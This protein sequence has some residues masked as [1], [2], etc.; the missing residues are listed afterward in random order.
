[1]SPAAIPAP[2]TGPRVEIEIARGIEAIA[3]A[4]WDACAAPG[5]TAGAHAANPFV[6]HAFLAALEASG[7]AT[8]ATGW[9]PHHLVARV[10][11]RVEAVMPLY[12]KGHS[13][14]EYVFDHAWANAWHRAGGAYYPKLQS[15]VPFTPATGP[16]LM[17]RPDAVLGVAPMQAALIG[18]ARDL[19]DDNG[20]SS[21]HITFCTDAEWAVG[22]RHG[23]LQRTDQQFHWIDRGYGD[24]EGF[25]GALA[26]RKRKQVRRER[27]G[28][29]EAGIRLHRLTGDAIGPEHWDAFW[30][31]YQDTGARKW[32]T[33]YLTRDFFDTVHGTMA[34][35]IL[36]VLAERE[37]RWIGG[38]LNFIG[39]DTLYGRYWGCS[40]DHPFLHFECC[41]YQAIDFALEH[42]LGRVEAGAQGAHKL[43]RG[44]EPVTTRSLHWIPDPGFRAAVARY[45]DEERAAVAAEGA[46]LAEFTPF[47]RGG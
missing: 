12:L 46:E 19:T 45:L 13:Q 30:L 32:G 35:D 27:A 15:A 2:G 8:A 16:R 40:E 41:Y 6:T 10:G 11:G 44:Y 5:R 29:G 31:F 43:A 22:A 28:A 20:L 26:S 18:T 36:L 23:L 1:M 14:G 37:G 33:P 3:P 24:F 9:A 39:A 25:L 34:D 21:L 47:R 38:A 4:D 17:V 42:G 7:S